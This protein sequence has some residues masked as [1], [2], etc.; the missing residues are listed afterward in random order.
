MS[1]TWWFQPHEVNS[2]SDKFLKN[3][4]NGNLLKPNLPSPQPQKV[5]GSPWSVSTDEYTI[6]KKLFKAFPN[7][8]F[9]TQ[10][11]LLMF[12]A[13]IFDPLGVKAPLT[14]RVR[15]MLQAAWN[16]GPKWDAPLDVQQFHLL[17]FHLFELP[18][19]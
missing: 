13:S 10:R 16:Q 3:V 8:Q 12:V 7:D 15:K 14:I 4:A 11:K 1:L 19:F 2:K 9:T 18:S 17:C 5:L 6:E